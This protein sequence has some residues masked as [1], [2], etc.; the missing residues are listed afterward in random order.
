MAS[1]QNVIM[2]IDVQGTRQFIKAFPDSL[3]IFVLRAEPRTKT[4]WCGDLRV[5]KTS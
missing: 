3:L 2:D 1:G 4:P 5:P